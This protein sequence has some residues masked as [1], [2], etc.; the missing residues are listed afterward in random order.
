MS[1]DNQTCAKCGKLCGHDNNKGDWFGERAK[2][3]DT[4]ICGKCKEKLAC[5]FYEFFGADVDLQWHEVDHILEGF[6][7]D[8]RSRC[9]IYKVSDFERCNRSWR[10]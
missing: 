8:S 9:C 7:Y 3:H 1:Q 5:R 2:C 10:K 6:E 4:A